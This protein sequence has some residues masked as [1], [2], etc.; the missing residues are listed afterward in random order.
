MAVTDDGSGTSIYYETW[1]GVAAASG[2]DR[3]VLMQNLSHHQMIWKMSATSGGAPEA[4]D[5]TGYRMADR[6]S[7][8]W[9][10]GAAFA[11][12]CE[13]GDTVWVRTTSPHFDTANPPKLKVSYQTAA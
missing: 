7:E 5:F 10:H 12:L 11:I 9:Q 13:D 1:T 4:T 2:S 8:P 3:N 6:G